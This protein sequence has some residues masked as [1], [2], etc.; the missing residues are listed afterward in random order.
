MD[1]FTL[2]LVPQVMELR[3]SAAIMSSALE[4]RHVNIGGL[5]SIFAFVSAALV[6]YP[7]VPPRHLTQVLIVAVVIR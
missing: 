6:P 7:N 1:A 3:V 4:Q 2:K 5:A